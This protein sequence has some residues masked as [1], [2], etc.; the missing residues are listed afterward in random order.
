[1]CATRGLEPRR[2]SDAAPPAA[3]PQTQRLTDLSAPR[4]VIVGGACF[5]WTVAVLL[6]VVFP[7]DVHAML[8]GGS[9]TW[10]Q[11]QDWQYATLFTGVAVAA[12]NVGLTLGW[13]AYL[14]AGGGGAQAQVVELSARA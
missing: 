6:R 14:R 13:S 12:V 1:M 7:S 8:A 4:A 5:A 3:R 9:G 2:P 11:V 10:L